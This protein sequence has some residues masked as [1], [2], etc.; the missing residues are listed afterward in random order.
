M[1]YN[2]KLQAPTI[3]QA[4]LEISPFRFNVAC[5]GRQ[6]GKTT[7][8][9]EKMLWK[10]HKGPRQA[11]YW[12]ILQTFAAAE[13]AFRRY[14][15]FYTQCPGIF[16]GK[17]NESDLRFRLK[18]SDRYIF[19]KSGQNYQ[20]LRIETLDGV[21]IDEMRQQ[22]P[23]LW[24]QIIRPMLAKKKAWADIYSTPNGYDHFF[25]IYEDAARDPEWGRFHAPSTEAPWWTPAEI[26]SAKRSMSESE[27]A[28]EIMAEFRD[29]TKGKVYITHGT[30]NQLTHT[31][32]V[33]SDPQRL[34]SDKYPILLGC[35]F[36]LSP[37]SWHL[38]QT[39]RTK[40]YFFDEIHLNASHTPEATSAL[41]EKLRDIKDRGLLKAQPNLI[42]C[43]DATGSAGQRAAAA[44]S[45]YDILLTGLRSAGFSF[46]NRT[47]DAN[48]RIKDRIQNMNAKLKSADGTVRFFY[49]PETCPALK[50]DFDRVV[51]KADGVLDEGKLKDLTHAS[52]SVGYPVARLSPLK[53]I[54]NVG[55]PRVIIR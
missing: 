50:K 32:F 54:N 19:F 46:D 25:D 37:M 39:D 22:N 16:D 14:R 43:G 38:G 29:L 11:V 47:P 44:Q 55:I 13:V 7:F 1:K 40:F 36:N 20:D 35:D 27:F 45:D 52:D 28:Q 53:G 9:T 33:T 31:P 34:V 42:I 15:E 41:I 24:T 4:K 49:N 12:Y 17:P 3:P 18:N 5:W 6:S 26:L 8:G 30:H 10:P 51:W 2:I 48:P 21:I 23:M